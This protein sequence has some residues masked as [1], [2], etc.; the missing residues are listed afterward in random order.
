MSRATSSKIFSPRGIGRGGEGGGDPGE[1]DAT[2]AD[3]GS[4]GFL[5][6]VLRAAIPVLP[7]VVS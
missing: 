3:R 6:I 1:G 2:G 5:V 4:G 7:P